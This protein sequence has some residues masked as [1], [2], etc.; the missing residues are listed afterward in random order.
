MWRSCKQKIANCGMLTDCFSAEINSAMQGALV[1][2]SDISSSMVD[3]AKRHHQEAVSRNLLVACQNFPSANTE[4]VLQ[5]ATV[6]ACDM[7]SSMAKEAKQREEAASS[8]FPV[9]ACQHNSFSAEI[10]SAM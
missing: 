8:E 5:G 1:S 4:T 6:S 2:A 3:E 9:V 10:D 7:S